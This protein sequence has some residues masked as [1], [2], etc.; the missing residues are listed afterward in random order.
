MAAAPRAQEDPPQKA[1]TGTATFAAAG[2]RVR[3]MHPA[4]EEG[5]MLHSPGLKANGK[6]YGFATGADVIVKLPPAR[7]DDLVRRGVGFPCSPRPGRPMKEW[8]RIAAPDEDAC[9]AYLLEARQ[10]VTGGA[11]S[12]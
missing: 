11:R 5:R 12:R 9:V 1:A 4:D 6:F 10:F 8:V 3:Q 2:D 7:V